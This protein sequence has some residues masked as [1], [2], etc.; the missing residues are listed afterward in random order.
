MASSDT[1]AE[2]VLATQRAIRELDKRDFDELKAIRRPV[3]PVRMTCDALK[4][5]LQKES[6]VAGRDAH[7]MSFGSD[8]TILLVNWPQMTQKLIRLHLVEQGAN[9]GRV[10]RLCAMRRDNADIWNVE[11]L[12]MSSNAAAKVTA[13]L[14]AVL[15]FLQAAEAEGKELKIPY[16]ENVR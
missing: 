15:D 2:A 16:D 4:I 14:F 11:K 9:L 13:W 12:R 8:C 6:L 3:E 7:G 10:K 5:L 1:L